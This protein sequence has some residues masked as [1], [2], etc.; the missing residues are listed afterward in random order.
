VDH[1]ALAVMPVRAMRPA[2]MPDLH[3]I[4][5]RIAERRDRQRAG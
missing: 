2:S 1:D 4:A 5:G 3:E